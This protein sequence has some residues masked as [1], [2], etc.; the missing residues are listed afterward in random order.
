MDLPLLIEHCLAGDRI[1][2]RQLYERFLPYALTVTRR[3]GVVSRY[4]A[5]AVQ[6]I[7][8]EVFVK[9]ANFDARKGQFPTWFRTIA[10]RK[11]VDFQ[12]RREKFGFTTLVAVLPEQKPSAPISF[13]AVPTDELFAAFAALPTG[14]RTV[15]NLYAIDGYRHREIA[16]LLGITPSASRSQYARAKERLRHHLLKFKKKQLA[17]EDR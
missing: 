7:F 17:H 15:F 4:Q 9:L 6:E 1:A 13:E 2:Q 5:D 12:R 14:F 10:V 16:D 8:A 3:Y 11:T